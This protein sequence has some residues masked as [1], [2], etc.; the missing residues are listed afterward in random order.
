MHE[1]LPPA[2]CCGSGGNVPCEAW[3]L[4]EPHVAQEGHREG[5]Q[6]GSHHDLG[7]HLRS[8][9]WPSPSFLNPRA[10]HSA[11][12]PASLSQ[13]IEGFQ[14]EQTHQSGF[15]RGASGDGERTHGRP[16][17]FPL[18][19]AP[20]VFHLPSLMQQLAR[21]DSRWSPSFQ[22]DIRTLPPVKG[23]G[24]SGQACDLGIGRRAVLPTPPSPQRVQGGSQSPDSLLLPSTHVSPVSS[25]EGTALLLVL[26]GT[27]GAGPWAPSSA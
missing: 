21:C 3:G 14:D 12:T 17:H 5:P 16:G 11:S 7:Q 23:P 26:L 27:G 22:S 13:L 4:S 15:R 9:W 1:D 6:S 20:F 10:P 24:P 8:D 25:R 18:E 2:L 19:R